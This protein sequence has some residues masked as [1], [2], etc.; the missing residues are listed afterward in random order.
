MTIELMSD[1]VLSGFLSLPAT[2]HLATAQP[3][4]ATVLYDGQTG[5]TLCVKFRAKRAVAALISRG[6]MVNYRIDK[7]RLEWVLPDA[8][9]QK[10]VIRELLQH[11]EH[12]E[13]KHA[14]YDQVA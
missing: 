14:A 6:E 8:W 2:T 7:V 9:K 4:S 10:E 3:V 1:G 13:A 12:E 11:I 5:I